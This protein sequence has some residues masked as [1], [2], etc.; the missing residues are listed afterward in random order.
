MHMFGGYS[1]WISPECTHVLCLQ[2]F[3]LIHSLYFLIFLCGYNYLM[4]NYATLCIKGTA[5]F[6]MQ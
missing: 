2:S 3:V 6:V 4:Y 5:A 1:V